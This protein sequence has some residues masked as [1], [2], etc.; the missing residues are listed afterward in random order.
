MLVM[1]HALTPRIDA[2]RR[3][4]LRKG[5]AF[6][7]GFAGLAAMLRADP[8]LAARLA[9]PA[10]GS[11]YGPL[12]KDPKG[13]LDLPAGFSYTI[14]AR[15]GE[16][17]S[18]GLVRPGKPDAMAAFA[19][20]G[21]KVL[22]LCNHENQS[23]WLKHGPFGGKNELLSKFD[24]S[25]LYDKGDSTAGEPRPGLGGVTTMVYNP[26]TNAIE[27]QWLS[28][29]GTNRNCAGGP[30][31]W[32]SWLSCEEDADVVGDNHATLNHGYVF[33][34]P[35]T[36]SRTPA[37]PTPLRSLGRFMHE[38]CCVD[39]RTGIVY[40]SEDRVDGLFYRFVPATKPTKAGD[41]ATTKG[42][43]Q[44]LVIEGWP[45]RD[46][47]NRA[48]GDPLATQ[49]PAIAVGETLNVRWVDLDDI[50]APKDDLRKRG[51]ALGA[52]RFA[53]GEGLWW[54]EE[55]HHGT[56]CV[57]F[58]AT[59]GGKA[60]RGQLWKYTPSAHEGEADEAFA[61]GRLELFLEPNDASVIENADNITVAP[62]GDLI[63]CEDGAGEQQMP[64]NR[65][66]RV[67][68][69][70]ACSVLASNAMEDEGEFAGACFSPDGQTLFV[71][72]Q[73]A[74]L[75]IAVRGPWRG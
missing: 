53:R 62:W 7:L 10:A 50:E 5:V 23:T 4:F 57:F 29:A 60:Q 41:L 39:P 33:E 67:T 28:L 2:S 59:T 73:S 27:A 48:E 3:D 45:S 8:A 42:R 31:P 37:A 16:P 30:T 74:G 18:D 64:S 63:V 51:F 22:L 66:I 34:V 38:A 11:G 12:V 35:A 47:G 61:Q 36:M 21:G 25:L 24:A 6:S 43:L 44:A 70:G 58:A 9:S 1:T 75:T 19:G 13:I 68:P 55:A 46:T 69:Q 15:Q 65:L 56:G 32:G 26:Q 49:Q 71:N 20:E 52:A 17:M 54:G 72:L 40:L 14:L